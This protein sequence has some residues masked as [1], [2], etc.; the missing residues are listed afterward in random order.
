MIDW[1]EPT[2]DVLQILKSRELGLSSENLATDIR[3]SF[4][5]ATE[6]EIATSMNFNLEELTE[7]QKNE[8]PLMNEWYYGRGYKVR[9]HL[10]PN[11][12]EDEQLDLL[13][14]PWDLPDGTPIVIV[15]SKIL[16]YQ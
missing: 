8:G 15:E 9:E 1:K 10:L 16:D 12:T 7:D 11:S 2:N 6:N 4:L 3:K 13:T 5:W 14:I